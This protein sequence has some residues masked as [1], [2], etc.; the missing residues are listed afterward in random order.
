M[1]ADLSRKR[2]RLDASEEMDGAEGGDQGRIR[3]VELW[4]EDGNIVIVT[5]D[6]TAFKVHRTILATHSGVFSDM[7]AMPQPP[8]APEN[9]YDGCPRVDLPEVSGRD[10]AIMLDMFYNGLP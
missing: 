7:F 3:D 8:Y 10:L 5:D 4:F 1:S 9:M 6:Y 2:A